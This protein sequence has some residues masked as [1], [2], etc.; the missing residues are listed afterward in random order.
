MPLWCAMVTR[1]VKPKSQEAQCEGARAAIRTELNKMSSKKVWDVDDVYE[2]EDLMR[3][4][5][6]NEAMLGRAFQILGIKNEEMEPEH[7]LWKGRIVFQG[8]NIKT[9]S[10]KDPNEIFEEC[11]NTPASFAAARTGLAVAAMKGFNGTLRDAEAAYLQ[12][13][14]DTPTRTPTFVSLPREWWPDS[15][16]H[17]GAQRQRPKYRNPYCRLLRAFYEHPEAGALWEKTL[18]GIMADEGWTSLSNHGGVFVHL[19]TEAIMVVYV[20]DMLLLA[21]PKDT[22]H[23]EGIG[24]KDRLQGFRILH[25]SLS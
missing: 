1:I 12:A 19:A 24:E 6:I 4:P 10:G 20:D 11:S 25:R 15:W 5:D 17:D 8:S 13:L 7:H 23:M 18:Q 22:S 3:A 14:I 16:F 9:K 21:R 2:Y